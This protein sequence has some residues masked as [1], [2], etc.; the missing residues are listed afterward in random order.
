MTGVLDSWAIMAWLKNES[1]AAER[2]RL[3][4][5]SAERGERDLAMSIV[6]LGEVFYS[7][8]KWKSEAYAEGVVASLGSH[9]TMI[10][11]SDAIVFDAARLKARHAVS[12]ADAFAAVTAIRLNIPLLTGDPELRIA[13]RKER[14]LRIEWLGA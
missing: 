3:L 11:A 6:N 12:Y 5:E 4:L 7:C 1:P 14:G 2:I 9:V 13:A 10:S 8:S